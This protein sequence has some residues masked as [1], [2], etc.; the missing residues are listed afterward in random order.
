VLGGKPSTLGRQEG[1]RVTATWQLSC[2]P[3]NAA[4]T[5][6]LSA[7]GTRLKSDIGSVF[8]GRTQS[9]YSEQ[10]FPGRSDIRAMFRLLA[11]R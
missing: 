9:Q 2:L 3:R 6:D 4:G 1:V 10:R 11:S 7:G 5:L 8:C